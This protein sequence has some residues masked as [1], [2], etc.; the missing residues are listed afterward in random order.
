VRTAIENVQKVHLTLG[1]YLGAPQTYREGGENGNPTYVKR[2]HGFDLVDRVLSRKQL[3]YGRQALVPEPESA[4]VKHDLCVLYTP[5]TLPP[6]L[7]FSL[8]PYLLCLPSARS[9]GRFSDTL[10]HSSPIISC[11]RSM[12]Y[13]LPIPMTVRW[14]PDT[15]RIPPS[16]L[17]VA[18]CDTLAVALVPTSKAGEEFQAVRL[19]VCRSACPGVRG[20]SGGTF[21][22]FGSGSV[23]P[24]QI[25]K[26]WLT[27]VRF[28]PNFEDVDLQCPPQHRWACERFAQPIPPAG[29]AAVPRVS[30]IVCLFGIPNE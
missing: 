26:I 18:A 3:S 19:L 1:R 16:C 4:C 27:A 13:S 24:R 21:S 22:I 28:E 25:D 12:V 6:S 2:D 9:L 23:R 15:R 10:S 7:S 17:T 29:T 8:C 30:A 14:I 5:L 20:P 11:P